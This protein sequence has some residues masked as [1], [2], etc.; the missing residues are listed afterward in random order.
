MYPWGIKVSIMEPGGFKTQLTEPR[1]MEKQ[2]RQGWDDLSEELKREY[3]KDYLEK[4]KWFILVWVA[5]E[6]LFP[7][8]PLCTRDR[9]SGARAISFPGLSFSLAPW[10]G[11]RETL[12][13]K[14]TRAL[15][16]TTRVIN[17]SSCSS[18][19]FPRTN[20]GG[21]PWKWSSLCFSI[22]FSF[23][24]VWIRDPGGHCTGSSVYGQRQLAEMGLG[25][26]SHPHVKSAFLTSHKGI[27]YYVPSVSVERTF[28]RMQIVQKDWTHV[29]KV[30]SLFLWETL[31]IFRSNI[32]FQIPA[33][34]IKYAICYFFVKGSLKPWPLTSRKSN[35][36]VSN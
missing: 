5:L 34:A 2:M 14:L 23:K 30:A 1:K 10:A 8:M 24:W 21:K 27:R 18:E 36:W 11:R 15:N 19:P 31:T 33:R 32:F 7:T 35:L 6:A 9:S 29:T 28:N 4:G 13:T 25:T 26:L 22:S 20:P 12:G 17:R 3:G 16:Q